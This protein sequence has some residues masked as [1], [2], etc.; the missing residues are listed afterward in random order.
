VTLDEKHAVLCDPGRQRVEVEV[1]LVEASGTVLIPDRER[2]VGHRYSASDSST[3]SESSRSSISPW[4]P[5]VLIA[6]SYM[7][8]SFGQ[9]TT[10]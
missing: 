2:D 5:E 1:F 7:V 4:W 3:S 6:S 8:T 10:K 9:A